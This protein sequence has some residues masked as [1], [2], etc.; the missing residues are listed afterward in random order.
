[1]ADGDKHNTFDLENWVK[2]S[3]NM[4]FSWCVSNDQLQHTA[5]VMKFNGMP[6]FTL[7]F[8]KAKSTGFVDFSK[9]KLASLKATARVSA[10][11]SNMQS[12]EKVGSAFGRVS[13]PGKISMNF[14]NSETS[15]MKRKLLALPL[16]SEEE[17]AIALSIL[18]SIRLIKMG[19][20]K[21]ME[22]N[23]RTYVIAVG[24][25]LRD[26]DNFD[27]FDWNNFE[28]DMGQLLSKDHKK[29]KDVFSSVENFMNLMKSGKLCTDDDQETSEDEN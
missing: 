7:D 17:K 16:V 26:A 6:V 12:A 21:F 13:L 14:Y 22:N 10:A 28:E 25:V 1:M 4:E 20:Y 15:T 29:F 19:K 11:L 24:L 8:G 3:A 5:I 9:I 18:E 27:S 2:C 23:C